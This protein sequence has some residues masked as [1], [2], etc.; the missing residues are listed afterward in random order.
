MPSEPN[1]PRYLRTVSESRQLYPYTLLRSKLVQPIARRQGNGAKENQFRI[2][3][4]IALVYRPTDVNPASM[5]DS[6]AP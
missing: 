6:L 2:D 4:L 1:W 5:S 3:I